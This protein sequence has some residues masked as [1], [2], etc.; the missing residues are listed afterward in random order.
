MY[1]DPDFNLSRISHI[2]F[3]F[4]KQLWGED[5]LHEFYDSDSNSSHNL[6]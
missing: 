6:C 5:A 2:Y 3:P 1:I 4:D